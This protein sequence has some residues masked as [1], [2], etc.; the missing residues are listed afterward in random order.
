[1]IIIDVQKIIDTP[2]VLDAIGDN[3]EI[4]I[5]YLSRCGVALTDDGQR[6]IILYTGCTVNDDGTVVAGD[7]Q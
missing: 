4:M 5:N 6:Q 1:M 7:W 3:A 2:E